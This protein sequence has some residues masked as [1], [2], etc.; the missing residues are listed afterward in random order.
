MRVPVVAVFAVL[1][2]LAA[3]PVATANDAFGVAKARADLP[4]LDGAGL[5]VAVIDTAV[6]PQHPALAGKVVDT[7]DLAPPETGPCFAGG[8]GTWVSGIIAGTATGGLPEGVAPGAQILGVEVVDACG[9]SSLERIAEGI[10]WVVAHRAQY[11]VD[12]INLS[13]GDPVPGGAETDAAEAAVERAVAAG[14]PVVAAAGNTGGLGMVASPASARSTIAVGA[15]AGPLAPTDLGGPG[16]VPIS[17]SSSGPTAAGLLKPDLLAAGTHTSA[18]PGDADG[19]PAPG[20]SG[21]AAFVS[22]VALLLLDADPT[23][24]P[25]GLKAALIDTAQ[26]WGRAGKDEDFGAGRLDAYAALQA[27]GAPLAAPPSV[28]DHRVLAGRAAAGEPGRHEIAV[29]GGAPLAITV[30]PDPGDGTPAMQLRLEGPGGVDLTAAPGPRWRTVGVPAPAAGSYVAT[31][32]GDG[33]YEIDISGALVPAGPAPSLTLEAPSGATPRFTGTAG[34]A[35][36]VAVR[37]YRDG[38]QVRSAWAVPGAGGRWAAEPA[39]ALPDGVYEVAAEHGTARTPR[40][41]FT[42]DSNAPADHPAE[43][44]AGGGGG[45]VFLAPLPAADT[46]APVLGASAPRALGSLRGRGLP[47][48]VRCDEACAIRAEILVRRRGLPRRLARGSARLTAAGRVQLRLRP[49]AAVRRRLRG[50]SALKV[51]VR[52]VATDGAGN[53]RELRRAIKLR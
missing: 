4:S 35:D 38:L 27:V 6:S 48:A 24:T 43:P 26:D 20:T 42:V 44:P 28:P 8:H 47:L 12:L 53:A 52:V 17:F 9:Q 25:A 36:G 11:G 22:G 49:S 19:L 41:A 45:G 18:W 51:T 46:A 3:A 7:V 14:I 31:V 34:G 13:I 50:V 15:M 21:A 29:T 5:V 33:M 23:L 2:A 37:V 40:R 16:F 10:D 1:A 32:T 39:V 30:T